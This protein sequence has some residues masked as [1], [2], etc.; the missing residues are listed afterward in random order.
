VPTILDLLGIDP[1]DH[2]FHGESLAS[3]LR[4]EGRAAAGAPAPILS[5]VDYQP[6]KHGLPLKRTVKQGIIVGDRKLI[7]DGLTG[8][9]ELY[10]LAKD[11]NETHDLA[12]V[13]SSSL[14]ALIPMLEAELVRTR[15]RRGAVE[16]R[17]LSPEERAQLR[18]LGYLDDEP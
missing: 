13:D 16:E 17:T 8:K 18:E 10:D 1:G 6:G 5:E 4:G 12:E 14:A 15:S 2:E 11:P 9:L 7:R 3:W